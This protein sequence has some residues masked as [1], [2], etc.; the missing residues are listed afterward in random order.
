MDTTMAQRILDECIECG[1]CVRHCTFLQ[2][3]FGDADPKKLPK[4]IAQDFL[5]GKFRE[6]TK[7]PYMCNL[8][9]TCMTFCPKKLDIGVVMMEERK[10]IAEEGLKLPGNMKFVPNSQKFV[11]GD[12]FFL[13]LPAPSGKTDMLFF[14]GCGLSG[15]SPELVRKTWDWLNVN[16]PDCGLLL[17]CCG[18]PTYFSGD[19]KKAA[20]IR[21]K[22]TNTVRDM[23]AEKIMV[24]CPD[25]QEQFLESTDIPTVNIYEVLEPIWT[26][27]RN[28]AHKT[29]EIHD[30]CKSRPFPEMQAAVR[31]L[32]AKAG[33]EIVD[34][35]NSGKKTRCCGQGGLVAYTDGEWANK[36]QKER[37]DEFD[38]DFVTYCGACRQ[39]IKAQGHDGVHLLDLLLTDDPDTAKLIPAASNAKTKANQLKTRELLAAG[40]EQGDAAAV[41]EAPS[42][43]GA[44]NLEPLSAELTEAIGSMGLTLNEIADAIAWGEESGIK[45]VDDETG[46]CWVNKDNDGVYVEVIYEKNGDKFTVVDAFNHKTTVTGW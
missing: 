21:E 35:K 12:D 15:Y 41:E 44:A 16:V 17:T 10:V 9:S 39:T 7:P 3:C 14:P 4:Q 33:Y 42:G 45:L 38:Q 36:V 1:N 43:T 20:E 34:P 40:T 28:P 25:C 18:G 30:P 13:A 22:L 32:A 2:S 46:Q 8:C 11:L 23:G 6:D 24:V 5:D 19:M 37:A 26:E 27:N 31:S 29:W